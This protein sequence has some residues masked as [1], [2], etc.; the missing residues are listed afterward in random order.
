MEQKQLKGLSKFIALL[1][2]SALVISVI[3]FTANGNGLNLDSSVVTD[4][5]HETP[6][7]TDKIP[8][9]DGNSVENDS[10]NKEENKGKKENLWY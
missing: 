7:S 9:N 1:V 2:I 5:P 4:T 3:I 6:P 10:E 8:N